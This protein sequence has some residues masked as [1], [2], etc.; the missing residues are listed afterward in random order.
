MKKARACS[1]GRGVD[2]EPTDGAHIASPAPT[3][4]AFLK[5]E[6][7]VTT[8]GIDGQPWPPTTL[9]DGW[10]LIR[11]IDSQSAWRRISLSNNG[12][13]HG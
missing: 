5:I 6:R 2:Q 7:A 9:L 11:T 10:V 4:Q 8:D 12:D 1:A 13:H 3:A